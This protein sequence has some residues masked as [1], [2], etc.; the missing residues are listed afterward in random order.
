MEQDQLVVDMEGDDKLFD[1]VW[2][3]YELVSCCV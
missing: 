3:S 2:A 1:D